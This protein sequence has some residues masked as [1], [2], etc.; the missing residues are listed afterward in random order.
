LFDLV[1][2]KRVTGRLPR[3]LDVPFCEVWCAELRTATRAWGRHSRRRGRQAIAAQAIGIAA[4]PCQPATGCLT[5]VPS[6]WVITGCLIRHRFTSE[7][8]GSYNPAWC[9]LVR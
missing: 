2:H 8:K 4:V 7:I 6:A 1:R 5:T 3:S 9:G